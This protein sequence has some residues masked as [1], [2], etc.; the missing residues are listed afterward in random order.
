MDNGFYCCSNNG[1][2]W[3]SD[4]TSSVPGG[5]YWERGDIISC[6]YDGPRRRVH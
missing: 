4:V 5:I 6:A 2:A 1:C 3:R